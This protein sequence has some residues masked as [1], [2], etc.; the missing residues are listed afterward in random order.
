MAPMGPNVEIKV[1]T[2]KT[3]EMENHRKQGQVGS[4]GLQGLK[5]T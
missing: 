2:H 3:H 5:S 4:F 1:S